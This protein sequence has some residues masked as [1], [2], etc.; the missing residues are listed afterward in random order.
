MAFG[1][2]TDLHLAPGPNYIW[3]LSLV[4]TGDKEACRVVMFIHSYILSQVRQAGCPVPNLRQEKVLL[5][6]ANWRQEKVVVLSFAIS[7]GKKKTE[8]IE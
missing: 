8:T 6:V 3:V 5:L 4:Q 2:G 7:A 1:F